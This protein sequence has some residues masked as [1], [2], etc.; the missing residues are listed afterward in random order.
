MDQSGLCKASHESENIPFLERSP[1]SQSGCFVA[2]R[3]N[4][5]CVLQ[6]DQDKGLAIF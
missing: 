1:F 3:R 6:S 5:I 2:R 4:H